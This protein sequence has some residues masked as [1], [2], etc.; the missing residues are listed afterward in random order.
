MNWAW[1]Q[2]LSPTPK[3]ILMALA[4]AAND[5]RRVLAQRVDGGNQVLCFHPHRSAGHANTR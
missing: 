2:Q 4:D 3:L 5:V 1:Q